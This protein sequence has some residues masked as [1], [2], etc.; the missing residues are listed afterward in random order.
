[1]T[2]SAAPAPEAGIEEAPYGALAD[3]TKVTAYALTNKSGVKA[4]GIT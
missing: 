4:K 3:G 1:M 2:R